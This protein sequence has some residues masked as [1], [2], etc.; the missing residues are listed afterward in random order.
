M[1]SHRWHRANP[2]E[3]AWAEPEELMATRMS[4]SSVDGENDKENIVDGYVPLRKL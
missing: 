1:V 3:K 2:R 4:G